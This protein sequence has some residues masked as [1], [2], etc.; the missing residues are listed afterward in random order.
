M[1]YLLVKSYSHNKKLQG[2]DKIYHLAVMI[3]LLASYFSSLIDYD[4]QYI[5]IFFI[6][7]LGLILTSDHED[8]PKYDMHQNGWRIFIFLYFL[9]F[10]VKFI[11]LK[12]VPEYS[13]KIDQLIQKNELVAA[14]NLALRFHKLDQGGQPAIVRLI[15]ISQK[16]GNA[17][18]N[19]YWNEQLIKTSPYDQDYTRRE[20]FRLYLTDMQKKVVLGNANDAMS[21]FKTLKSKYPDLYQQINSDAYL[22]KIILALNNNNN[23]EALEIFQSLI[24]SG[25]KI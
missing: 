11:L 18:K 17:E 24:I 13:K 5:S 19:H 25:M 3:G 23:S 8:Q 22:N 14:E 4:W 7:F 9:A 6:L 16:S 10:L 20:D 15:E 12:N 2:P 1:C 21:I